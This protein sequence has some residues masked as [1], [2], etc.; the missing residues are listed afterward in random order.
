MPFQDFSSLL[1][2]PGQSSR[3]GVK[4]HSRLPTNDATTQLRFT[5]LISLLE[6]LTELKLPKHDAQPPASSTHHPSAVISLP[7]INRI[8]RFHPAH[9]HTSLHRRAPPP[10]SAT[11]STAPRHLHPGQQLCAPPFEDTRYTLY[12]DPGVPAGDFLDGSS[13]ALLAQSR[14]QRTKT[15]LTFRSETHSRCGP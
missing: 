2:V 15:H 5:S 9:R 1:I 4:R 13:I 12:E 8:D 3:V 11:S 6:F 14:P 7:T 10:Q